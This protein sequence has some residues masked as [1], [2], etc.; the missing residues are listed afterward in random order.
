L[1]E[2][3]SIAFLQPKITSVAISKRLNPRS[4]A[5]TRER[6]TPSGVKLQPQQ[7]PAPHPACVRAE[8]GDNDLQHQL[9]G[10]QHPLAVQSGSHQIRSLEER[11]P[12]ERIADLL[13]PQEHVARIDFR[14][15]FRII[16]L[17][18]LQ[19]EFVSVQFTSNNT[20]WGSNANRQNPFLRKLEN[21]SNKHSKIVDYSSNVKIC[22]W[23]P[24][25]HIVRFFLITF[26][27]D[28]WLLFS[29]P[30]VNKKQVLI[31]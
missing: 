15:V 9:P 10:L 3:E 27:L 5:H 7:P 4:G 24:H 21:N 19:L 29:F 25:K 13:L 28:F 2:H 20:K 14:S 11:I 26:K 30:D 16:L 18:F 8:A 31:R 22:T 23:Y 1:V 6:R 12:H 17:L